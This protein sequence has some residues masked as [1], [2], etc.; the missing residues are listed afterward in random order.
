MSD[1]DGWR[2][3]Q[4]FGDK[5]QVEVVSEADLISTVTFDDTGKCL[6]LIH[7]FFCGWLFHTF[8]CLCYY[9][10]KPKRNWSLFAFLYVYFLQRYACL[11][12]W[13][14]LFTFVLLI[15]IPI[16][17]GFTPRCKHHQ[18]QW[19]TQFILTFINMHTTYSKLHFEFSLHT[20]T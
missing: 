2:F 15:P 1:T 9:I 20:I 17:S 16:F 10:P 19:R 7:T 14:C 12:F 4:V 18:N 13:F 3:L 8:L 5:G 6:I 11:C